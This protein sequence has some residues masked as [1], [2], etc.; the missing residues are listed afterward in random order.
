MVLR[1]NIAVI[2]GGPAGLMAAEVLAQ[3]GHGVTVYDRMPSPA[4]KLLI[5]GRGGLNLTHSEP[6]PAFISRYGA[7]AR[8]IGPYIEAF[9]PQALRTWCEGLGQETFVGSSGRVFPRSMKAV[10]LLRAWLQRL[11]SLGVVYASRH[12][13]HG[14]KGDKLYFTNAAGEEVL[15]MPDA[16]LLAMGGASWPRLGS[17]GAWVEPVAAAGSKVAPLRPSNC[18]FIVPWSEHFGSRYG[19]IPL[20]PVAV[21]YGD[22][23]RQGEA[24]I[25]RQGIEGGVI[26]AHSST[27]REAIAA[28]GHATI[29]LDLR[30]SITRE[31]LAK[32]L[33][34]PRNGKSL[35]TYLG[36]A[37]F[38]PVITGLLR[39][40]TPPEALRGADGDVLAGLLKAL[41]LTLTA[42]SCIDRAISSAGGIR[43]DELTDDLMLKSRNGVF[44]AGEMIDWEAP[45]GGYLLQGCYSTAVAAAEGIARYVCNR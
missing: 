9:P 6:L 37:G 20:K 41:P 10:Q 26:Y 1:K 2:G 16:T 11:D 21:R 18:G 39:E 5:A 29:L 28:N 35:S 22:V 14:W 45:T 8:W 31:A 44:A 7:A 30:P 33:R 32:K 38:S 25:T 13:W 27:L 36:N 3:D 42:T 17:D 43:L 24:M 15:V 4:R 19:G 23:V 12:I 40:C 34:A